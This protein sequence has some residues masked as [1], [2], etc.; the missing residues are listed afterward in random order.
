MHPCALEKLTHT[1]RRMIMEH[2][3][4]GKCPWGGECIRMLQRG[5]RIEQCTRAVYVNVG[6]AHVWFWVE[7][8]EIWCHLWYHFLKC[9]VYYTVACGYLLL[10]YIHTCVIKFKDMGRKGL[11]QPQE[12]GYQWG[13]WEWNG[14]EFHLSL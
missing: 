3:S 14:E 8:G 2:Y 4:S 9:A 5:R 10:L 12:S 13:K 11:H 6:T 7:K 1:P